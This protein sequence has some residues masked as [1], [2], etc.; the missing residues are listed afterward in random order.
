MCLN[1]SRLL[2]SLWTPGIGIQNHLSGQLPWIRSWRNCNGADK[3]SKTSSRDAPCRVHEKGGKNN[4]S[5][6]GDTT[7][8]IA[9]AT[10]SSKGHS[11]SCFERLSF[12]R[13]FARH[14]SSIDARTEVP[15]T[16]TMRRPAIALRPYIYTREEIGRLMAAAR[17][18]L[19]PRK[20]RCHTYYHLLGLL[21]TTGMRSGEA[22]RLANS[23]VNLAEGLITIRESKFGKSR[24]VPLHPTTVRALAAYVARR[25]A[26]LKKAEA[27]T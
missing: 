12:I 13:S 9:W 20:L 22:V 1:S 19:S 5:R 3:P 10:E 26:F 15:P 27:S 25:D 24:V 21:A 6:L 17:N 16:G 23:D 2:K 4:S 8:A 18:L 11:H 14:L 7:L